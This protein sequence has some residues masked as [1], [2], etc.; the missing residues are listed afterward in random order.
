M[1][2]RKGYTLLRNEKLLVELFY[3]TC[4]MRLLIA[5]QN[6][7]SLIRFIL[8][9]VVRKEHVNHSFL[10]LLSCVLSNETKTDSCTCSSKPWVRTTTQHVAFTLELLNK[11]IF[12]YSRGYTIQLAKVGSVCISVNNVWQFINLPFILPQK[13]LNVCRH[14]LSHDKAI[15][16]TQG[17][18]NIF[19]LQ[20]VKKEADWILTK[21]LP[22]WRSYQ[23]TRR[24]S[25]SKRVL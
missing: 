5:Y 9:E 16:Q 18:C 24:T 15:L 7:R 20:T 2:L 21:S 11:Q 17:W 12:G 1:V 3:L 25:V 6:R 13:C 22:K 8:N 19:E 14:H 4:I 23:I 10:L